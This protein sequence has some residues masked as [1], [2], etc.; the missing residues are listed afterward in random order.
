LPKLGNPANDARAIDELLKKIGFTTKLV[1]DASEADL[2]RE[3]RNFA[4]DSAKADIAF[5]FMRVTAL[6]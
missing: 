2:R 5:F 4:R 6:R 3:V 1:P